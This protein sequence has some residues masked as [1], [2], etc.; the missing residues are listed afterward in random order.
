MILIVTAGSLGIFIGHLKS[1]GAAA[2]TSFTEGGLA[3]LVAISAGGWAYPIVRRL[4]PRSTAEGLVMITASG[5]GMWAYSVGVLVVGSSFTGALSPWVWWAVLAVG[6]IL[7]GYQ[8]R[9]ALE[10][11]RIPS[12][13]DG[14]VL[15][16]VVLGASLGICL[17]GATRMPGLMY[18]PDTYDVLEYH[19]QVPREFFSAGHISG[20]RHNC[21]SYYPLGV[22]MLFLLGMCLRNGAYEGMYA[23]KMLHVIFAVMTVGAIFTALRKDDESRGRFAAILIGTIPMVL[24]L[25]CLGMVELGV[26]FYTAL[27][28]LWLRE[29]IKD[30]TWGSAVMI[31]FALGASCGVKYLSLGLVAAP[32]IFAMLLISVLTRPRAM[33]ISQLLPVIVICAG[34]FSPWWIRNLA[35]TGNPVFPLST[36]VFGRGHWTPESEQRWISGHGP[37]VSP[38]VPVPPGWEQGHVRTR[39][40]LIYDNLLTAQQMSPMVLLLGGIAICMLVA[41]PREASPWDLSLGGILLSQIAVWVCLT[42]EAPTRFLV[43]ALVP[44]SLLGGKVLSR[45]SALRA[46][47]FRSAT[48]DRPERTG[49]GRPAAVALLCFAL[50][51]NFLTIYKMYR[52]MTKG[53]DIYGPMQARPGSLLDMRKQ[54]DTDPQIHLPEHTRFMLIGETRTWYWPIGTIYATAFDTHPLAEMLARGD[55]P[56]RILGKLKELPVTHLVVEWREIWRLASSYGYHASL[57]AELFERWNRREPPDLQILRE[58]QDLG[59]QKLGDLYPVQIRLPWGRDETYVEWPQLTLYALPGISTQPAPPDEPERQDGSG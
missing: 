44:V 49:W 25:G 19:L 47:P 41:G 31:A 2:L 55:S 53:F 40:E 29:W 45:I 18:T 21:Y 51:A 58:L 52:H 42:H 26:I 5:V 30:A 39:G 17:A 34:V 43:P 3:L 9:G 38:P 36:Q 59:L 15:A 8:G 27:A 37:E 20:L 6:L 57:S 11:W 35:A 12:H 23:A 22:E 16:W 4:A 54:F 24:Y 13:F 33:R 56:E 32:L 50:L 7:A 28:V 48:P 14:R 10:K 46:N 1:W